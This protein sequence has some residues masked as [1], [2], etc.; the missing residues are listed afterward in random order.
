[1]GI[2]ARAS[3][4]GDWCRVSRCCVGTTADGS[5][6]TSSRGVSV[7]AVAV[8]ISIAYS[9]LAGVPPAHGLYAS[10][11]PLLAYA[12]FGSS[13]QLIMAPDAATC[14]IVAAT[15]L[16]LAGADPHRYMDTRGAAVLKEVLEDLTRA[17]V[18]VAMAEVKG[19]VRGMLERSGLSE[20]I[21][22]HRMFPTI[23]SAVAEITSQ[24]TDPALRVPG[25]S[26]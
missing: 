23:E 25:R 21:G 1:M 11:L 24:A 6:R 16:P 15:V 17:G 18:E 19:P 8:P 26:M 2:H 12:A 4:S 22:A 3:T 13:R 10:I 20:Q 9:E 7:A 5:L 14:A